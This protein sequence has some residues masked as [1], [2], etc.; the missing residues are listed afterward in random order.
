M[1]H[2]THVIWQVKQNKW[3]V[4]DDWKIFSERI[5]DLINLLSINDKGVCRTAPATPGLLKKY[6]IKQVYNNNNKSKKEV[7]KQKTTEKGAKIEELDCVC[8]LFLLYPARA[9]MV[10]PYADN[11][12]YSYTTTLSFSTDTILPGL[13]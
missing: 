3:L 4:W 12:E 1:W 8:V 9:L 5:T 11:S 2:M 13:R 7:Y 6:K 10:G